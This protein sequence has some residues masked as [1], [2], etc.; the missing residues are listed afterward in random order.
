LE[1]AGFQISHQR[2][3]SFVSAKNITWPA[4]CQLQSKQ[5]VPTPYQLMEKVISVSGRPQST[6]AAAILL[7]YQ[8]LPISEVQELMSIL[9]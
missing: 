8:L 6:I 9:K 2:E 5:E 3:K 1:I 4:N 7:F